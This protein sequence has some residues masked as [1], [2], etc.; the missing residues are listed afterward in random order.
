MFLWTFV[1]CVSAGAEGK[2]TS[3]SIASGATG[4]VY[5]VM[6]DGMAAMLTKHI[7]GVNVAAEVTA[8]SV[9][10]CKLMKG[11]ARI[12]FSIDRIVSLGI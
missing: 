4:G 3:F 12:N 6:G 7:P 8:A 10:N 2:A 9:D 5:F 1:F 11:R